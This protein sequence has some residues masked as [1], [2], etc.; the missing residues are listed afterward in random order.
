M[1]AKKNRLQLSV[2]RSR[3]DERDFIAESHSFAKTRYLNTSVRE[4]DAELWIKKKKKTLDK[5][6][7]MHTCCFH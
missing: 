5:V 6:D 2:D 7:Y 3:N 4:T 1:L